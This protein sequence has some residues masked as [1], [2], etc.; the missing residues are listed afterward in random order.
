MCPNTAA[1]AEPPT[2]LWGPL[3]MWARAPSQAD[4]RADS[5]GVPSRSVIRSNCREEQSVEPV[6]VLDPDSFKTTDQQQNNKWF[7]AEKIS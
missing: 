5:G 3:R 7:Q 2:G 6:L 4:A 1:R